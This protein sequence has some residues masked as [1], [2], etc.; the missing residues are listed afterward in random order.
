MKIFILIGLYFWRESEWVQKKSEGKYWKINVWF[1]Y[2]AWMQWTQLWSLWN[3]AWGW[4]ITTVLYATSLHD[5]QDNGI[6]RPCYFIEW[7]WF[8][9]CFILCFIWLV[10]LEMNLK[11]STMDSQ[12]QGIQTMDIRRDW[13]YDRTFGAGDGNGMAISKHMRANLEEY[14]PLHLYTLWWW[15]F[16][17][18]VSAEASSLAGHLGLGKII[19]SFYDTAISLPMVQLITQTFGKCKMGETFGWQVMKLMDTM[20]NNKRSHPCTLLDQP[21]LLCCRT[22]IAKG[23]PKVWVFDSHG[24]PL[25]DEEISWQEVYNGHMEDQGSSRN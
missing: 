13:D 1:V 17:G 16:N 5:P 25:G 2:W 7:S 19:A 21:S 3:G 9:C 20:T 6:T 23:S 10:F 22:V 12:L 18:R 11:L 15:L 14:R 4:D 8:Q 24:S